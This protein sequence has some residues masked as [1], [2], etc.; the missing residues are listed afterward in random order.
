MPPADGSKAAKA[1][2]SPKKRPEIS[3]V[4][5]EEEE[6]FSASQS[7]HIDEHNKAKLAAKQAKLDKAAAVAQA[8]RDKEIKESQQCLR[9]MAFPPGSCAHQMVDELKIKP[10]DLELLRD[11]F[12]KMDDDRTGTI[13]TE[14]FLEFCEAK[15]TPYT[16]GLFNLFDTDETGELSFGEYFCLLC[17]YCMWSQEEVYRYCFN[18]VDNDQSGK[19]DDAEFMTMASIMCDADPTFPGTFKLALERFD[20]TDSGDLDYPEFKEMA[21]YFPILIFPVLLLQEQFQQMT[22]GERRWTEL[23]EG[24]SQR[25]EI[26]AML[27][28]ELP[29]P[30]LRRDQQSQVNM[31]LI[32]HPY[33][34]WYPELWAKQVAIDRKKKRKNTPVAKFK[35]FLGHM[36]AYFGVSK[37]IVVDEDNTGDSKTLQALASKGALTPRVITP[38]TPRTGRT[39]PRTPRTPRVDG[40]GSPTGKLAPLSD[41]SR[42]D[43]ASFVATPDNSRSDRRSVAQVLVQPL[44]AGTSPARASGTPVEHIKTIVGDSG[45]KKTKRKKQKYLEAPPGTPISEV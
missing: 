21:R 3:F 35:R 45:R 15:S 30:P 26:D 28:A 1:A 9:T 13:S 14:E 10:W 23:L 32:E 38:R 36:R 40:T 24:K 31:G 17:T 44:A 42:S 33:A 11:V 2:G 34:D 7:R 6:S 4:E 16:D 8:N 22:L 19:I 37:T 41:S 18:A 43:R 29:L 12:V 25:K 20:K 39:T 5:P 27:R